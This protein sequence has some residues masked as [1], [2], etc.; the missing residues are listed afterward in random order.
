[1]LPPTDTFILAFVIFCV[2]NK[3]SEH[4]ILP[5]LTTK[6]KVCVLTGGERGAFALYRIPLQDSVPF[7]IALF[8]LLPKRRRV[9]ASS[10][11]FLRIRIRT[12]NPCDL[13]YVAFSFTSPTLRISSRYLLPSS[14]VALMTSSSML[15][16]PDCSAIRVKKGA[17]S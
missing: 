13:G 8:S 17:S 5:V 16:Q 1:M 9:S 14:V 7:A 4:D 3:T 15:I 2:V 12:Q 6:T 11:C 10:P